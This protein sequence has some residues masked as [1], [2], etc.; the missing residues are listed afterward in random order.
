MITVDLENITIRRLSRELKC[1]HAIT[2]LIFSIITVE[3][4]E[5][6]Q[7]RWV[8]TKLELFQEQMPQGIS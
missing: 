8:V 4:I 7:P 6:K 3:K 5:G 1:S 2:I